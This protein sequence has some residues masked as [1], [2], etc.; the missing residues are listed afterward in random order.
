MLLVLFNGVAPA[1]N[2]YF[3]VMLDGNDGSVQ[4]I[5][6]LGALNFASAN[7]V[8]LNNDGR[9][10]GI[11]S[12]TYFDNGYFVNKVQSID[13]NND[14]IIMLWYFATFDGDFWVLLDR[15]AAGKR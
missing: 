14:T 10:E 2:D 7:A 3:Q 15:R 1:Y 6:S 4:F 5:D 11:F 12:I 13:F 8:D 9:D